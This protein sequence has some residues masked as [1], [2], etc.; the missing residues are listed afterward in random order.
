MSTSE[1]SA[2]DHVRLFLCGYE[3]YL[4]NAIPSYYSER[5]VFSLRALIV[6]N[7]RVGF[8]DMTNYLFTLL[9]SVN[10]FVSNINTN[11]KLSMLIDEKFNDPENLMLL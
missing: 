2:S 9:V 4:A 6:R 1:H 11:T 3:R 10:S 5:L 8:D 7:F